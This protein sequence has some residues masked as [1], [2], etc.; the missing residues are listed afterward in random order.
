MGWWHFSLFPTSRCT[1]EV[2]GVKI[3]EIRKCDSISWH[4]MILGP[5][6]SVGGHENWPSDQR[7]R[8]LGPQ[9]QSSRI[10]RSVNIVV[11]ILLANM[12]WNP[13]GVHY[14]LLHT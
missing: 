6:G 8:W 2:S 9:R 7:S 10:F 3:V 4:G 12:P 5:W 14:Y 13:V 1:R 11:T